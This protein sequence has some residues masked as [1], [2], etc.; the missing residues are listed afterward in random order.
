MRILI[1]G[2]LILS[3]FF[4]LGCDDDDSSTSPD[5]DNNQIYDSLLFTR[6][7]G[8]TMS[9]GADW[10][11]CCG[12]WES[13]YIE[14][15][16]LKILV[17]DALGQESGFKLFILVDSVETGF[18]YGLPTDSAGVAPIS[19]FINDIPNTNKLNSAQGGS[20]GTFTVNS[21]SCG[22]PVMLDISIDA[23]LASETFGS[24]SVTIN[25]RFVC[26]IHTNPATFGCDFSF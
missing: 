14:D 9:T 20:I 8:G 1:S 12:V 21:I 22:P 19:M 5:S 18:S 17:Y 4:T 2:I 3:I 15:N 24:P 26:E 11:I 25:G 7:G 10:A 6:Q 16:T 13:G 23:T